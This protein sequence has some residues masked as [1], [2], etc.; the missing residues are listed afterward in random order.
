MMSASCARRLSVL[1]VIVSLL[2]GGCGG[3]DTAAFG[4]GEGFSI[5]GALGQIPLAHASDDNGRIEVYAA[6]LLAAGEATGRSR[7]TGS[8]DGNRAREWLAPMTGIGDAPVFVALPRVFRDSIGDLGGFED[9]VGFA[10][11]DVDATI[12]S[13]AGRTS[14]SVLAGDLPTPTGPEVSGGVFTIGDGDDFEIDPAGRTAARPFGAPLRVASDDGLVLLS[15]TTD[16]AAAW[17]DAGSARLDSDEALATAARILDERE[18]LSAALVRENFSGAGVGTS[19]DGA[20]GGTLP[21][22]TTPFDT[23]AVGWGLADGDAV[24]TVVYVTA[25][26]SAARAAAPEIEDVFASGLSQRTGQ[27]IADVV[28]LDGVVPDGRAVVATLGLPDDRLR[29]GIV[30]E[31]LLTRDAPF[32]FEVRGAS[33]D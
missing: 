24:V 20:A 33:P 21:V 7:P 1:G 17:L 27:P 12:E 14:M 22:I 23:V 16:A 9:E 5:N 8:T 2:A 28:T 19:D 4:S 11:T 31:M 6:D 29:P 26:E 32:T 25:D 13:V 18:V 30:F 15:S 10:V 3:D